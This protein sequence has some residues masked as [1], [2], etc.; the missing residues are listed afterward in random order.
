MARITDLQWSRQEAAGLTAVMDFFV[1][2]IR[3]RL[4][5]LSAH[6]RLSTVASF[7]SR[8]L[9][10]VVQVLDAVGLKM[11]DQEKSTSNGLPDLFRSL[12]RQPVGARRRFVDC[13]RC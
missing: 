2:T 12:Y 5:L 11:A 13:F 1:R 6:S 10:R 9:G 7:A 4:S 3:D 8:R